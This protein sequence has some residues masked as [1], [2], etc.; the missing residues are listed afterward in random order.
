[1]LS[2]CICCG[3]LDF[4]SV[5]LLLNNSNTNGITIKRN[6][7][8]VTNVGAGGIDI[9]RSGVG[10]R[11]AIYNICRRSTDSWSTNLAKSDSNICISSDTVIRRRFDRHRNT[12]RRTRS[13]L[14]KRFFDRSSVTTGS[15]DTPCCGGSQFPTYVINSSSLTIRNRISSTIE[16]DIG[17]ILR[18]S[19]VIDRDRNSSRFANI[20]G[21][22]GGPASRVSCF[23]ESGGVVASKCCRTSGSTSHSYGRLISICKRD[24]ATGRRPTP[25]FCILG[26]ASS[27]KFIIGFCFRT[28]INSGS[29]SCCCN[30]SIRASR[31]SCRAPNRDC[32]RVW[33][34]RPCGQDDEAHDHGHSQ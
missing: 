11:L 17:N 20:D 31:N 15:Q 19:C 24:I 16:N 2:A 25:S 3:R 12:N 1:M 18:Q 9:A 4:P 34:V 14:C 6:R 28:V 32:C 8:N 23:G 26:I 5:V 7:P 27:C 22:S 33:R 29:R 30:R 21:I 10:Q 13:R